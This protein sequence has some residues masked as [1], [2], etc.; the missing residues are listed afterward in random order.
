M[1]GA[2]WAMTKE[3]S[4]AELALVAA[5]RQAAERAEKLGESFGGPTP[6]GQ[7]PAEAVI[8]MPNA[9]LVGRFDPGSAIAGAVAT[10]AAVVLFW[11][12]E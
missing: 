9:T 10:A 12:R 5:R 2:S 11:R 8:G 1:Y 4:S 6:V 7:K 3:T